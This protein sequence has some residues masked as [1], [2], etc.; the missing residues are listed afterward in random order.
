MSCRLSSPFLIL[1]STSKV[2][3]ETIF[4]VGEPTN[5]ISFMSAVSAAVGVALMLAALCGFAVGVED[6]L[7][8]VLAPQAA[9]NINSMRPTNMTKYDLRI[10]RDDAMNR[11]PPLHVC[12]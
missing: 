1:P 7:A 10:R 9:N 3:P 12:L 5:F 2:V 11:Y 4:A 8:D 6:E